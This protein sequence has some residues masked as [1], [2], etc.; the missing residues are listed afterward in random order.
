MSEVPCPYC[1]EPI[2]QAARKC[3]HCGE[4]LDEELARQRRSPEPEYDPALKALVPVGRTPLSIA[5]GYL[6]LL[7]PLL[8]FAPFALA[9][10][11]LAIAEIRRDSSKGGLGRAI[12]GAVMGGLFT[13]P[14]VALLVMRMR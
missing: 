9:V 8:C 3:R 1:A 11:I 10:G 13:I 7:S 12:F 2:K 5:A 4:F 6:G 14:F